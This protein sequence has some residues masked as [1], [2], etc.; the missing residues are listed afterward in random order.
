MNNFCEQVRLFIPG[1]I[2]ING[3]VKKYSF[4][5]FVIN[6]MRHECDINV[7]HDKIDEHQFQDAV[8]IGL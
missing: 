2:E 3:S 6:A 4:S 5:Q 7:F 1:S 8:I